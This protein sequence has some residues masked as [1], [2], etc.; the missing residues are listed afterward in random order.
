MCDFEKQGS[1]LI[2]TIKT[3]FCI[4]FVKKCIYSG[5]ENTVVSVKDIIIPYY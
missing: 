1:H 4:K 2:I 5:L 3:G